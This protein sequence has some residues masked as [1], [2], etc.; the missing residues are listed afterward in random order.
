MLRHVVLRTTTDEKEAVAMLVAARDDETLIRA[1]AEAVGLAR[2]RN[3]DGL[4]LNLHDRPGPFLVGRESAR[5]DGPGHVCEERARHAFLVS[6]TSFFQTN[7][8]PPAS[9]CGSW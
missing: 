1:A 9:W 5:V 4:V 6:P 3:P 7:V 8:R 2:P